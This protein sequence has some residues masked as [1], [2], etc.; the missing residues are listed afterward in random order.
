MR[1]SSDIV[2]HLRRTIDRLAA[3]L[4]TYRK[5][6]AAAEIVE[7]VQQVRY[8]ETIAR[9]GQPAPELV[10]AI[11]GES[12]DGDSVAMVDLTD[13]G[14]AVALLDGAGRDPDLFG[15]AEVWR[16]LNDAHQRYARG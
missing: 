15:E 7:R 16:H 14:H 11:R 1:P 6:L 12:A 4:D 13:G 8:D 2:I 10:A 9:Y 3:E 5:Q